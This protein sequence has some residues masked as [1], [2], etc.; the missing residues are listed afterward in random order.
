M[1]FVKLPLLLEKINMVFW[2]CYNLKV[3]NICTS[4]SNQKEKLHIKYRS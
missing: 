4:N 1:I 2:V 3:T